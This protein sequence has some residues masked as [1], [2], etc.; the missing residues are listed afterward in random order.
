MTAATV[1]T[2]S[3]DTQLEV[4]QQVP[5]QIHWGGLGNPQGGL[6][7]KLTRCRLGK[8]LF[9][10]RENIRASGGHFLVSAGERMG[11]KHGRLSSR[12]SPVLE[13]LA[14]EEEWSR[15]ADLVHDIDVLNRPVRK[16]HRFT[17]RWAERTFRTNPD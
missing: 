5:W 14:P 10:V 16:N 2:L 11:W 13:L 6:E 12:H 3:D 1:I 9:Y 7:G 4:L 17:W 15:L 8:M